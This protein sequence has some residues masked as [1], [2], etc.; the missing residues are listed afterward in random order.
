MIKTNN[1]ARFRL[2][3]AA[4]FMMIVSV[5]CVPPR[6][7][8]SWPAVSLLSLYG[9]DNIIVSYADHIAVLN[10]ANGTPLKV[11][12]SAG[13]A[14]KDEN[15]VDRIWSFQQS[16]YE[17]AQFFANPIQIDEETM[18][19]IGHNERLYE[20][21]IPSAKVLG[22]VGTPLPGKVL[23]DLAFDERY[24]FLPL[25][26]GGIAA[27]DKDSYE[28]RW[29]AEERSQ[30][31]WSSPIIVEDVV[32]FTALDHYL[33]AINAQDGTLLWR[34]DLEGAALA[35]PLFYAGRLFVGSVANRVFEISTDG[36][37]LSQF[38]TRDWVWSRPIIDGEI[39]YVA[40][41]GGYVYALDTN[42]GLNEVW[43]VKVSTRGIRPS[44]IVTEDYVIVASR[45][46]TVH[47]LDKIDGVE[48]FFKEVEGR[49]EILSDMLL[50][51][52][53]ETLDLPEPM[54]I[55]ATMNPS[56]LLISYNLDTGRENWVYRR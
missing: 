30:G 43:S 26:T 36:E 28:T 48:L 24:F 56:H 44:P 5:S 25:E 40:D 37:I 34:T 16:D 10:P 1:F 15:G 29:V 22:A 4:L 33:Y 41:L 42:D 8:V 3:V 32:Y 20:L 47:W 51:R 53:S 18:L 46:G 11:L 2:G 54:L 52:P 23:A 6:I 38:Q 45:D 9:Q 17:G 55:V 13:Q 12:D 31:V 7:G 19:L 35:S 49:P 27:L 14:R 39:L 50:V 21:D